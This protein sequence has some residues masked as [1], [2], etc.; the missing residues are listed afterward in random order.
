MMPS[1]GLSWVNWVLPS[2]LG[3]GGGGIRRGD[4]AQ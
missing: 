1:G 4:F 3:G 2:K